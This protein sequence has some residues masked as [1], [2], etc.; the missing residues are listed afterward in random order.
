MKKSTVSS[1]NGYF[2]INYTIFVLGIIVATFSQKAFSQNFYPMP[3]MVN[4]A[5]EKQLLRQLSRSQDPENIKVLLKLSYVF[6]NKPFKN[7][8]NLDRAFN[9][10]IQAR[11][12]SDRMHDSSGYNQAQL[13]IS[14][15]YLFKEN[16]PAAERVLKMVNDTT[17]LNILLALSYCY[18]N[19]SIG[20]FE[21]SITYSSKYALLAKQLSIR[22]HDRKKELLALF[23]L[24]NVHNAQGDR[25]RSEQEL[26]YIVREFKLIKYPYLHYCYN[27]LSAINQNNG[28]YDQGLFYA[29]ETIKSMKMTGDST[30]AGEF[31]SNLGNIFYR[32]GQDD[33][34][35]SAYKLAMVH[36]QNDA[37]YL[38]TFYDAI[39][40][41]TD[42]LIRNHSANKAL[43]FLN[44]YGYKDNAVYLQ[45]SQI[46]RSY[47][48][49]YLALKKFDLAEKYYLQAFQIAKDANLLSYASY[50]LVAKF[51]VESKNFKK[52]RPYLQKALS[53][54]SKETDV[55]SRAQLNYMLFLA[56]STSGDYLSAIKYLN[57]KKKYDDI[58]Y[59]EIKTKEIQKML[60]H[61]DTE[62]KNQ[63]IISLKQKEMLHLANL[64]QATTIRNVTIGWTLIMFLIGTLLFRQYKQKQK[65]NQVIVQKNVMQQE[66]LN[67]Q[68]DLLHDKEWLLKEIH[69][70]V[71]NNHQIA[72]SLI[73]L[74]SN[75]LQKGEALT[76][77]KEI[78]SRMNAMSL[79]HQK[80]Y[81]SE[82]MV[83]I[84]MA[85][86]IRELADHLIDTF[87]DGNK[88]NIRFNFNPVELDV[89]QAV[90]IGLI[91][92][93][94][95]TN[96]IKYAFA[97]T[98]NPVIEI[99]LEQTGISHI[100]LV[101]Q[102]NGS[103]MK[104]MEITKNSASIGM[105][106]MEILSKQLNGDITFCSENGLRITINF[107][108]EEIN[109]NKDKDFVVDNLSVFSED[110][111]L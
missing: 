61:Y 46:Y 21:R 86:Y 16:F 93:E 110:E 39:S 78:R 4:P 65:Y 107:Q 55:S 5:L 109:K 6:L 8:K 74:Q 72:I 68:Q 66:M 75:Y 17:R 7:A 106:L 28:N 10:A 49:C 38:E 51:Y 48:K 84:S 58:L 111:I 9:Y 67:K 14:N 96:S 37:T 77:I 1:I 88:I 76:A 53:T 34:S 13:L 3:A 98:E 29:L 104:N 83:S 71:K 82:S 35:E 24:A 99:S 105:V 25:V 81:M 101:I 100:K 20:S 12:K 97:Q 73:D 90:P 23:Y 2:K 41:Y 94:A 26:L 69:H 56:D 15:I 30:G 47:A 19:T 31:Y 108:K 36:Y 43:E 54:V 70:R 63:E 89:S 102:D 62:K 95:I 85:P 40:I 91:L 64:E 92:N 11:D 32:L 57:L 18:L 60:V 103:G 52:A 42:L 44:E 22:L 87:S 27:V 79:I 33:E 50:H 45:L 80:L 59:Q